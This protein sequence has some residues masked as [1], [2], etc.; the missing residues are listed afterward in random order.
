MVAGE[1][2]GGSEKAFLDFCQKESFGIVPFMPLATG[3]LTGRYRKDNLDKVS[4]R[5]VEEE[6]FKETYLTDK[7]LSIVEQL[8]EIAKE[9]GITLPQLAIAWLLSHDQ[10]CSVIAGV[11]KMNQLEDNAEA[12]QV[13]LTPEELDKIDSIVKK[14]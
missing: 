4:G 11:T 9:K 2:N 10:V 3:L 5:T 13:E 7:N 8:N 6:I 12:S 1:E 14:G